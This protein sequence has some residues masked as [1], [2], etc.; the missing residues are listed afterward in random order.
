MNLK[1]GL[2]SI[3]TYPYSGFNQIFDKRRAK[4]LFLSK[5]PFNT[6]YHRSKFP[7]RSL[8]AIDPKNINM[9]MLL[10]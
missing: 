2:P 10:N 6:L 4:L 7:K 3:D 1:G 9:C 5:I 8:L